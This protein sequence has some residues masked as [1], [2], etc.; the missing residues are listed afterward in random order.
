M[1]DILC[2]VLPEHYLITCA[3]KG[4]RV[5]NLRKHAAIAETGGPGNLY[6]VT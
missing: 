1:P 3:V 4:F 5:D 2:P 6:G